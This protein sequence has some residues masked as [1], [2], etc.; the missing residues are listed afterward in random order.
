VIETESGEEVTVEGTEFFM[1]ASVTG[2]VVEV[3]S[4]FVMLQV[5]G[6]EPRRIQRGE[7]MDYN[8]HDNGLHL[9][10][11]K[12]AHQDWIYMMG[13]DFKKSGIFLKRGRKHRGPDYHQQNHNRSKGHKPGHGKSKPGHNGKGHQGKGKR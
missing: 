5:V 6:V 13:L 4:G 10:Q 2:V 8:R 3:E 1:S 11:A 9:G 7:R 12:H